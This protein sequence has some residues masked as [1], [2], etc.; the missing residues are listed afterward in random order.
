MICLHR[1]HSNQVEVLKHVSIDHIYL[2]NTYCH[3]SYQHPPQDV[4][5][6][7]LL[8][9]ID[10]HPYHDILLGLDSLGKEEVLSVVSRRYSALIHVSEPQRYLYLLTGLSNEMLTT[11]PEDTRFHVVPRSLLSSSFVKM[12]PN[13]PCYGIIVSGFSPNKDGVKEYDFS[14]AEILHQVS[15]LT[16]TDHTPEKLQVDP[17]SN[18]LLMQIPYSSHCNFK[19]LEMFLK[20]VRPRGLTPLIRS[21]RTDPFVHFKL[22]ISINSQETLYQVTVPEAVEAFMYRLGSSS[23]KNR[24][25]RKLKS[26]STMITV[27]R[28]DISSKFKMRTLARGVQFDC[29]ELESEGK[30]VIS[31]SNENQ[32]DSFIFSNPTKLDSKDLELKTTIR[33]KVDNTEEHLESHVC[34]NLPHDNS[35]FKERHYL[36]Q[37]Q[38]VNGKQRLHL[39]SWMSASNPGTPK[40]LTKQT[41]PFHNSGACQRNNIFKHVQKVDCPFAVSAN[42]NIGD[43]PL[44]FCG[45]GCRSC[46][47]VYFGTHE[48]GGLQ[49]MVPKCCTHRT[50]CETS[51]LVPLNSFVQE[52]NELSFYPDGTANLST[53]N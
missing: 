18:S 1:Y 24:T 28:S 29:E 42:S 48:C 9:V 43:T 6:A 22:N 39:P 5:I 40:V 46:T 16:N 21:K 30:E 4:A 38:N 14:S 3:P 31:N 26:R 27:S 23:L 34:E 37:R 36:Q 49:L 7:R 20:A 35:Q 12:Y 11:Q 17:L 52:G 25:A 47:S 8:E 33:E 50:P 19:E 13:Q 32:K 15:T 41:A 2:D 44:H 45:Q 53:D 10:S 51:C